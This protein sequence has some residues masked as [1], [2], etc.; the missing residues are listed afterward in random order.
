MA[1]LGVLISH[2]NENVSLTEE[3][4]FGVGCILSDLSHELD[5]T[6]QLLERRSNENSQKAKS[7]KRQN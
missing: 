2:F 4:L 3:E 6:V 5:S 1:G 7:K